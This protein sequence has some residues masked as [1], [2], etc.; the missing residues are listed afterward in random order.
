MASLQTDSALRQFLME[1]LIDTA[2]DGATPAEVTKIR[3]VLANPSERLEQL[4][5]SAIAYMEVAKQTCEV[6]LLNAALY[7]E[8]VEE[9]D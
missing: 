9:E 7:G 1:S 6:Q 3:L 4:W 5:E 8:Y 2:R